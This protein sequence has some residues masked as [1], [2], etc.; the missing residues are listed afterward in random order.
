MID[1][2]QGDS[3]PL[4]S[5]DR[6]TLMVDGENK[7]DDQAVIADG[8]QRGIAVADLAITSHLARTPSAA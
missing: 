4:V 8:E 2:G 1:V 7:D 6:F 3:Q 5:P